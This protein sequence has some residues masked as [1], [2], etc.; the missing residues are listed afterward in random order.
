MRRLAALIAALRR[1]TASDE[2]PYKLTLILNGDCPTRCSFCSIW[3]TPSPDELTVEEW[4]RVF[5]SAPETVW[6]NLS[7]GEIFQRKDIGELVDALTAR[8]PRLYLVDFPTTGYF[9][10]RTLDACERLAIQMRYRPGTYSGSAV[11]FRVAREIEAAHTELAI[12]E[13]N[14]RQPLIHGGLEVIPAPGGHLDMCEEPHVGVLADQLTKILDPLNAK[15]RDRTDA[16]VPDASSDS[17][18]V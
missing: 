18:G 6:A 5:A 13:F 1:G 7:G 3:K 10:D 16:A 2:L 14:G 15:W 12:D 8:M 17:L 11:L 4:D 9:V